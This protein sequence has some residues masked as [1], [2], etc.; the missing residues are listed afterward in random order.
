MYFTL[1]DSLYEGDSV[2]NYLRRKNDGIA[3]SS[4]PV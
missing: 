3:K 4:N 2:D 1:D